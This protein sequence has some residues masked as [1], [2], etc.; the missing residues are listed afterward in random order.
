[1]KDNDQPSS[2]YGPF[3]LAKLVAPWLL[4]GQDLTSVGYNESDEVERGRKKLIHT[5]GPVAKFSIKWNENSQKYSGLFKKC[6]YGIARFSSAKEPTDGNTAPG[7]SVKCLRDKQFGGSFPVMYR[8]TGQSSNNWFLHSFSNHVFNPGSFNHPELIPLHA[9]FAAYDNNPEL[10]GLYR[11]GKYTQEGQLE[12]NIKVPFAL[13]FQP[14]PAL[15]EKCK[16]A[17]IEGQTI[18][19]LKDIEPNTELYRIHGVENPYRTED[20]AGKVELLGTMILTD[21]MKSSKFADERIQ[22]THDFWEDELKNVSN[23]NEWKSML[24]NLG[25]E[26]TENDEAE[27][28]EPYLT[29][30]N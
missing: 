25:S 29:P 12:A 6:D 3:D 9:K 24:K 30:W 17:K 11:M 18:G 8:L 2:Y 28:M 4:G 22:F 10:I 21:R 7:I 23:A 26:F 13:V 15:T 1:M 5:V 19:C 16:N 27:R 20:L 14:N